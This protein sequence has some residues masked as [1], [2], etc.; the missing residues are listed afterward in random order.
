[1]ANAE[2]IFN[3]F[4]LKGQLEPEAMQKTIFNLN[5]TYF[6]NIPVTSE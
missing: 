2:P 3:L 1:M 6:G 5:V 4:Q